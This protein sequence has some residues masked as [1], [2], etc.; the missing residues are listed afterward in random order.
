LA[1]T[2][3]AKPVKLEPKIPQRKDVSGFD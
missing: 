1:L 2:E 3:A